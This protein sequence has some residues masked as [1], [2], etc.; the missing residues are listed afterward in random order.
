MEASQRPH[1]QGK[2]KI[3]LSHYSAYFTQKHQVNTHSRQLSHHNS[4]TEYEALLF[5]PM[6]I[7]SAKCVEIFSLRACWTAYCPAASL[8]GQS[9]TA[10]RC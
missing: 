6:E 3:F 9:T 10:W 7:N 1:S 2:D 5:L 8:S 4:E